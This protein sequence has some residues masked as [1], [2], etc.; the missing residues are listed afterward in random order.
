MKI[1]FK[2]LF[3]ATTMLVGCSY[4]VFAQQK[5][6]FL[7]GISDYGNNREWRNINGAND[8]KLLAPQFERQGFSVVSLIDNQAT[9]NNI[10]N[11]L[12]K[13]LKS[14]KTGDVVYIHFSM[15]GQL[16][17]DQNGDEDDGWDEAL[18]PVDAKMNYEKGV[19]EGENHLIDDT[20]EEY[21]TRIRNKIGEMGMLYVVLDACH[22][23]E[24]S[25]GGS[26]EYVRGTEKPF[27][28]SGKKYM[29]PHKKNNDYFV[30]SKTKGQSPVVFIEACRSDQNNHEIK[31]EA[32]DTW[33]GALSYYISQTMNTH[34][35]GTST[36][37][38]N[39]VKNSMKKNYDLQYQDMV[40][41]ASE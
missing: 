13:L 17:E 41:E 16:V 19:Y 15:H 14:C 21:T 35:I 7:V 36:D 39:E 23:G 12:D 9:Y 27:S 24:A 3:I 37:W 31:I 5:L 18:V 32:T 2:I 22:S 4:S 38:I 28:P 29:S 25:R 1:W 34:Q 40:I 33:Y 8:V 6:A 30:V 11:G 20:I 26:E 10:I